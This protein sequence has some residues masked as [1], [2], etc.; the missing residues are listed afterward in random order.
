MKVGVCHSMYGWF[1]NIKGFCTRPIR[2]RKGAKEEEPSFS[3][4]ITFNHI[5]VI[6]TFYRFPFSKNSE[7]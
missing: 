4:G 6:H 3:G 1:Y 5:V 2:N 7:R